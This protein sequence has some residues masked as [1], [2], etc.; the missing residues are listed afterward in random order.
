M[1][2]VAEQ[3]VPS[4]LRFTSS[5]FRQELEIRISRVISRST[6]ADMRKVKV[7]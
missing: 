1:L 5:G 2:E 6:G 7:V 4:L 3:K